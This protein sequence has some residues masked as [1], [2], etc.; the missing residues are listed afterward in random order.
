[1]SGAIIRESGERL[2]FEATT[3]LGIARDATVTAHPVERGADVVDHSQ[4][5]A[6]VITIEGVVS[7]TL[8]GS[9]PEEARALLDAIVLTHVLRDG[10]AWHA[11]V[12]G[13]DR[14]LALDGETLTLSEL[15]AVL[16]RHG[17]GTQVRCTLRRGPRVIERTVELAAPTVAT[18]LAP[19]PEADEAARGRF[20]RWCGLAFPG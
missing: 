5:Q 14:L 11:G 17:P 7:E 2:T 12:S 19:D 6:E 16:R 3:R 13:G 8:G 9:R 15:P 10:P 1:M 20:Q 18:R 4:A